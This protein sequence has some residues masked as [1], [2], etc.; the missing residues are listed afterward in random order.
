MPSQ[1]A[2]E[3]ATNSELDAKQIVTNS[4]L[5]SAQKDELI[6]QYVE[7][8][9]DGMEI[10]DLVSYVTN[11]ITDFLEKLTDSELKEEISLTMDEEIYD[12]LVDNVTNETV[13][14]INNNGG[15]F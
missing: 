11:D 13:L 2:R 5:T 12:E 10:K 1:S 4:G 3:N 14:D 7:L 9:V 6:E 15:K 8:I